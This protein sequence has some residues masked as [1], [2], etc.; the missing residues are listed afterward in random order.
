M[1]TNESKIYIALLSGAVTYLILVIF[2]V[3][4]IIRFHRHKIAFE[5]KKLKAQFNYLDS[6]RER[7]GIDLHDDL[8]PSLSLL[9]MKL[10]QLKTG[11]TKA[12]EIVDFCKNH[13]DKV[14]LQVKEISV[15]MIPRTLQRQGVDHALKELV[16]S[17]SDSTGITVKFKYNAGVINNEKG[18][19]I[20][21]MTQ[22]ILNNI[23]KHSKAT[24]VEFSLVR[25]G[26]IIQVHIKDNGIG[27]NKKE[28]VNNRRGLGL[29]NITFRATLLKGSIYLNTNP[30]KGVD[31]LIQIPSNE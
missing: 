4:K 7:I 1:D 24:L 9:K 22:E 28:I 18:I 15:S 10:G 19:Q 30:G 13:L 16:N 12:K 5:D 26:N 17:M 8:G 23:V 20:Y 14:L 6:I 25:N 27:F 11:D 21:R 2:F 3:I 29:D 31:Y